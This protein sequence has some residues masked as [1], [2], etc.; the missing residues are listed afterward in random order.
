MAFSQMG[1]ATGMRSTTTRC[2]RMGTY[3]PWE[4][5]S[6]A[7]LTFSF[8][9]VSGEQMGLESVR[10]TNGFYTFTASAEELEIFRGR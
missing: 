7:P 3:W 4:F 10:V 1:G 8:T 6:Q 5:Q 2:R 9:A